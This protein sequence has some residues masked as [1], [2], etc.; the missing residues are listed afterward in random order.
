VEHVRK[1]AN[2]SRNVMDEP[3][4]LLVGRTAEVIKMIGRT[5][6]ARRAGAIP[7]GLEELVDAVAAFGR[8]DEDEGN[9]C[10]TGFLPVDRALIFRDVR[11]MHGIGPGRAPIPW[12]RLVIAKSRMGDRHV[13]R[14]DI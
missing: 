13:P 7:V 1:A 8:L 5:G 9:S 12:V 11:S 4:R 10:I 2:R 3:L 6:D 14:A